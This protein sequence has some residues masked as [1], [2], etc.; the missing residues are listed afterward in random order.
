MDIEILIR[1]FEGRIRTAVES[2]E[3]WKH[4]FL[5]MQ[6]DLIQMQT[7]CKDF[8]VQAAARP[9]YELELLKTSQEYKTK[10]EQLSFEF[11]KKKLEW[12]VIEGKYEVLSISKISVENE[13]KELKI[14]CNQLETQN[15]HLMEEL[16]AICQR[17]TGERLRIKILEDECDQY[18]EK[19]SQLSG[20]IKG[21]EEERDQFREKCVQHSDETKGF[22]EERDQI[23]GRCVQLS[24]EIKKMEEERDQFREKCVQHSGEIKGLECGKTK[25]NDEIEVLKE[26]LKESESQAAKRLICG[27]ELG[28]DLEVHKIKCRGLS[29]ELKEKEME[30]VGLEVKLKNLML[31][32]VAVE[33]E[34]NKYKTAF[35]EMQAKITSL[36]RQRDVM[37][38]RERMAQE[39]N[40]YLEGL[41][42][43]MENDERE[44]LRI[45]QERNAYL[46]GV[47]KKMENDERETLRITQGRNVYLEGVVKKME[48]DERETLRIAYER[49]AYL[50]GLVKKMENNERETLRMAQ[51]R[52]AYL[53]GLV[54]KMEN[55]ER[56]TVVQLKT[57]NRDL[58]CGKQ[59][60]ECEIE[61]WKKRFSALETEVLRF[62]E[63][64][65]TLRGLRNEVCRDD[66][67]KTYMN[68][69]TCRKMG[70]E[71]NVA[72]VDHSRK[73]DNMLNKTATI[74]NSALPPNP[75]SLKENIR[76]V[77]RSGPPFISNQSEP[78]EAIKDKQKNIRL[79]SKVESVIAVKKQLSFE[80]EGSSREKLVLINQGTVATS[81]TGTIEIDDS[82]DEKEIGETLK[83]SSGNGNNLRAKKYLKRPLS[84]KKNEECERNF[85]ENVTSIPLS[86]TTKRRRICGSKSQDD[87]KI[88][89]GKLLNLC[90]GD[91]KVER[92]ESSSKRSFL[93]KQCQKKK[94][95]VKGTSRNESATLNDSKMSRMSYQKAAK[96]TFA[97]GRKNVLGEFGSNREGEH[98]GGMIVKPSESADSG[99]SSSDSEDLGDSDFSFKQVAKIIRL[100]QSKWQFEADLFSSLQKDP[101]LCMR[102]ICALYRQ[103]MSKEKYTRGSLDSNER[104]FNV[105]DALR[106]TTLAEFLMDGNHE[107]DLKKSVKE[108]EMFDSKALEDC[109]RL[110]MYYSTQ[111]FSMYQSKDDPFFLP[112]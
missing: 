100:R 94:N 90:N 56:E 1:D 53:E 47:V 70:G 14:T 32:K 79:D 59:S 82:G 67:Y 97:D 106:G 28:K 63:E 105:N 6:N 101:E 93:L 76:E 107:G 44:T 51:E 73:K 38:D 65:A 103:Q 58:E 96:P 49:N 78:S 102:A 50:E 71:V 62:K 18:R 43:K 13:V 8:E 16:K 64:N 21:L 2:S 20:E 26:K 7:K 46:E 3:Y 60:A 104:G 95:M 108:L 88:P 29:T 75:S 74:L 72:A 81:S 109:K 36:E 99:D 84:A 52:N 22:E 45:T 23:R 57:Q 19:C 111:L 85:D 41:V 35:C 48:N 112:S 89:I 27:V 91:E 110:S 54:K 4:R 15:K 24:V 55:D 87:D 42:K 25:L 11:Q 68:K 92:Q 66:K 83:S 80:T 37:T 86:S 33:D 10:Y 39:R 77:H 34:L 61:T 9:K 40:A 69:E 5:Q 98:F 30:C 17:V 12:S 31:V